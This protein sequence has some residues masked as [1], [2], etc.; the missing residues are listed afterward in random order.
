MKKVLIFGTFDIVH[1]GHIHM[2][3]EAK[4]YGD[5]LIVAV[6]RDC[7]VEKIKD[8]TIIHNEKERKKFLE[9]IK[10]IDKVLL[11]HKNKPYQIIKKIKPD[12][13]ALGYDQKMYVDNLVDAIT[14]MGLEIQIVRLQP[15]HENRFKS[16]KFRKYIE[17]LV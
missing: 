3:H 2:F 9:N 17:K 5:K 7:N 1:A 6:A 12:V 10:I 13:I 16:S 11:G 4:E 15:Y 14:D 8:E